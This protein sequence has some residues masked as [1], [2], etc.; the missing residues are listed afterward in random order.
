MTK[1]DRKRILELVA[2]L[3]AGQRRYREEFNALE[4]A[5]QAILRSVKARSRAVGG[6]GGE[7]FA[8]SGEVDELRK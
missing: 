4:N 1:Q 6:F 2:E 8:G 3:R 7:L 5:K